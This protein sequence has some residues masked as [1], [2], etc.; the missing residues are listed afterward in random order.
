MAK[1]WRKEATWL[2]QQERIRSVRKSNDYLILAVRAARMRGGI[3]I[4]DFDFDALNPDW[5]VIDD[6][7]ARLEP[8][9]KRARDFENSEKFENDKDDSVRVLQLIKQATETPT[10]Q[11]LA[12]FLNF[13]T[14]FKRLAVWNARMAYIQRPGAQVIASEFE[15]LKVGRT[16]APDAVPIIILWPFSPIRFVYELEDTNPPTMHNDIRDPFAA[17]GDFRPEVLVKLTKG[18][19]QQKTFKIKIVARRLGS[20]RAGSAAAQSVFSITAPFGEGAIIGKFASENADTDSELSKVG[21]PSFRIAVNDRLQPGERFSESMH[22]QTP[23]HVHRS[24]V[25]RI[26]LARLLFSRPADAVSAVIHSDSLALLFVSGQADV[27]L[28]DIEN[29][30]VSEG[31]LWAAVRV[32]AASGEWV[33][34]GIGR[35][36]TRPFVDTLERARFTWWRVNLWANAELLRSVH[37]RVAELA[38][39]SRYV[40][41]SQFSTLE[42]DAKVVARRLPSRWPK[43]LSMTHPVRML[44]MIGHFLKN[45]AEARAHANAAFVANELVRSREFFD[46]IET[47]PLTPEQRRAVVVDEDRNLV[48]A[49]AGSGKTSVRQHANLQ[50][51]FKTVHRSKGLEADYVIV[52]GMCSGKY[53]FP[54][55]IGDDPILDIVLAAPE[56]H[57]NAEERRLFYVAL[58][59]ARRK[60]F[61]LA[62]GGEVSPFVRELLGMTN[63]VTVFGRPSERDIPCPICVTGR[64][65]RRIGRRGTFYG[66]SN[67][68]YCDYKQSAC[69]LCGIGTP[70]KTDGAYECSSC[71]QPIEGCPRCNGW[72]QPKDGKN[73]RFLGCTNW[74]GCGYTRH[75]NV[76]TGTQQ[77][78]RRDSTPRM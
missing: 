75:F 68:P 19:S 34:S 77:A 21:I 5:K 48:V 6:Q 52:A 59:R 64:L 11:G 16:I 15:W 31:L 39:P 24:Q 76:T 7:V 28:L 1:R 69:P 58:T 67:G 2:D 49:A 60:V 20:G 41:M 33:L 56:G 38:D 14:K 72:L 22:K 35:R 9:G 27:P 29:I 63:D 45:P 17:M 46:C 55:E 30:E 18:L 66:C 3:D 12:D 43:A 42:R 78:A 10:A 57:P 70:S 51:D 23:A 54:T 47:K 40:A 4:S 71:D 65:E 13:T 36:E 26:G 25:G 62:E 50:I 61:L 73:G 74:P 32:R 37:S 8:I 53:G 44:T